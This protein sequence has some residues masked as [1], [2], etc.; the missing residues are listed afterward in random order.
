MFASKM[1]APEFL[2]FRNIIKYVFWKIMKCLYG[3]KY[4]QKC[5]LEDYEIGILE[6]YEICI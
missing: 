3:W 6:D 5:Y 2:N 1:L 4:V